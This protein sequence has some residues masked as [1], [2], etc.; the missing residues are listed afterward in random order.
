MADDAGV[1]AEAGP[2]ASASEESEE[3]AEGIPMDNDTGNVMEQDQDQVIVSAE[4]RFSEPTKFKY[5]VNSVGG[6]TLTWRA[7]NLSGKTINYYTVNISTFNPVGDPSYDRHS[8]ESTFRIRYVGPVE[9][10]EELG[11][12]H[13][14]TYQGALHTVVIDSID[15][16]YAD[17]TEEHVSYDRSTSDNSGMDE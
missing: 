6:I 5:G 4:E 14:F 13:L 11:V 16:E 1:E 8:N 12:F 9:P 17:G 7:S 10:N 3:L 2:D 15:L